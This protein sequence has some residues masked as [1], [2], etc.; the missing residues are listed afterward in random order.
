MFTFDLLLDLSQ[1]GCQPEIV[2]HLD[3]LLR[4]L[5]DTGQVVNEDS[6]FVQKGTTLR[7]SILCPEAGALDTLTYSV[8]TINW[9]KKL[10]DALL[11]PIRFIPTGKDPRFE[12]YIEREKPS[13]YVLRHSGYSPLVNGDTGDC[14]P[15]YK[16]PQ[17]WQYVSV[18]DGAPLGD[19][20]GYHDVWSWHQNYERIYGL[21][22]N[23]GVGERFALRQMQ[24]PGSELSKQ[25]R[26]VCRSI[27]EVSGIPAY[28]FLFNYRRRNQQ[29]ESNWKCPLSGKDWL[30]PLAKRGDFIAFRCEESRLV[31]SF[32]SNSSAWSASH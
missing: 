27:E 23:G 24:D 3:N 26:A 15:L 8:F 2:E 18:M 7:V 20:E 6:P 16:I 22:F 30:L 9:L 28:Y 32:T 5:R 19:R 14:I 12:P 11:T 17:T 31:S 1:S 10:E 4:A 29:R 13:F 25:G 21:W